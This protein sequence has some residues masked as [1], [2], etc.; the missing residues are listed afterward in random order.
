M[1]EEKKIEEKKIEEKK[2]EKPLDKKEKKAT[3]KILKEQIPEIEETLESFLQHDPAANNKNVAQ[4][5]NQVFKEKLDKLG[6]QITEQQVQAIMRGRNHRKIVLEFMQGIAGLEPKDIANIFRLELP[7]TS[8][9]KPFKIEPKNSD[10]PRVCFP[11][12]PLIGLG[13][14]NPVLKRALITAQKRNGDAVMIPGNLV[15]LDLKRYSNKKPKRAEFSFE[16]EQSLIF[17]SFKERFDILVKKLQQQFFDNKG[18]PY[19]TGKIL[20]SLGRTEMDLVEQYTNEII[21]RVVLKEQRV[22]QGRRGALRQELRTAIKDNNLDKAKE[23]EK[24]I[25]AVEQRLSFVIMTNTNEGYIRKISQEMRKY[26]IYVYEKALNAKVIS[27]GEVFLDVGGMTFQVVTDVEDSSKS[28]IVRKLLARFRDTAKH[29]HL[30]HVI[31]AA[32]RTNLEYSGSPIS[33]V[34]SEESSACSSLEQ[35]PCCI[36]N[37]SLKQRRRE[38]LKSGDPFLDAVSTHKMVPGVMFYQGIRERKSGEIIIRRE[39][40]SLPFLLNDALFNSSKWDISKVAYLDIESDSHMGA[41][42]VVHYE[43]PKYPWIRYHFQMTQDFL[44]QA[45]APIIAYMHLGDIIQGHNF[46]FELSLPKGVKALSALIST[47]KEGKLSQE[48]LLRELLVQIKQRGVLPCDEQINEYVEEAFAG[49]ED[50]F[51]GIIER[52]KKAGIKFLGD[53]KPIIFLG[54]NHFKHTVEGELNDGKLVARLLKAK[55]E[56]RMRNGKF[57]DLIGS[58]SF[59]DEPIGRGVIQFLDGVEFAVVIRHKDIV[60]ASKYADPMQRIVPSSKKRGAYD[61]WEHGRFTFHFSGHTHMGGFALT[62]DASFDVCGS[63]AFHDA[64]GDKIGFPLNYIASLIEGIPTRGLSW[65]PIVRIPLE[66]PFF[67]K[68]RNYWKEWDIDRKVLFELA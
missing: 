44:I 52:S 33:Y 13:D 11:N 27:C 54:G 12:A 28:T 58:P 65:G 45:N 67:Q 20:I 42:F 47:I 66:Y 21:R 41:P 24:N 50:Y 60:G 53:L 30:P 15:W 68:T 18:V 29:V 43:F 5:L 26:I 51:L 23:L 17:R 8:Y 62:D 10:N 37:R 32:G 57:A 38:F 1:T 61:A 22:L 34:A 25:D 2:S 56:S 63:Q 39:S 59:G 55:L 35:L 9:E 64:Y 48:E 16:L 3:W 6:T 31:C 49:Y 19:F 14:D 4:H 7:E 40:Y 36:D 46:P